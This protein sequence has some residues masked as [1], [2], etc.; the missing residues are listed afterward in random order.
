MDTGVAWIT[1]A[2]VLVDSIPTLAM[3]TRVGGTLIN[4]FFTSLPG[5]AKVTFAGV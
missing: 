3:H 1:F 5:E 4:V 2:G